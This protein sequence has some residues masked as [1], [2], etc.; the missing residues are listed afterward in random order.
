[1]LF[2]GM[3]LLFVVQS[4]S[5]KSIGDLSSDDQVLKGPFK[6]SGLEAHKEPLLLKLKE[7][8]YMK[9]LNVL[10]T[11]GPAPVYGN[12]NALVKSKKSFFDFVTEKPRI[13]VDFTEEEAVRETR[14]EEAD[15]TDYEAEGNTENEEREAKK[16]GPGAW[17]GRYTV[18]KVYKGPMGTYII[19][20]DKRI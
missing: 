15:D 5:A 20:F 14:R 3:I 8:Q 16:L 11:I 13:S 6:R 12:E 2:C 18:Y 9:L 1:M 4:S 17:D 10:S 7:N 19:P